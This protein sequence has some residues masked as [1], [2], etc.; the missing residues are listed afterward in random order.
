MLVIIAITTFIQGP[1]LLPYQTVLSSLI[2]ALCVFLYRGAN[3]ARW[4]ASIL[5]S[6]IGLMSLAGGVVTGVVPVVVGAVRLGSIILDGL[7]LLVTGVV[8]ASSATVLI[9]V[10]SVRAYFNAGKSKHG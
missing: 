7:P 3:W 10:P 2:V 5:F 8:L 1:G 6:V 9:F 4:A